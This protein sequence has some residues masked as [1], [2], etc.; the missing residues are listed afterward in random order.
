MTD[1]PA[2]EWSPVEIAEARARFK[3]DD[4]AMHSLATA[5][6]GEV[7]PAFV[8]LQFG[9]LDA[10][11]ILRETQQEQPRPGVGHLFRKSLILIGRSFRRVGHFFRRKPPF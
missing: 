11:R 2:P 10:G 4:P 3:A 7:L 9:Y 1:T 8:L 6:H 5:L